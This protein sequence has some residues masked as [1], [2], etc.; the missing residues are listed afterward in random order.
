MSA[1]TTT[2]IPVALRGNRTLPYVFP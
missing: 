1:T 2:L